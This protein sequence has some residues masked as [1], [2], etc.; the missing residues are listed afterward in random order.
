MSLFLSVFI[1]TILLTGVTIFLLIRKKKYGLKPFFISL[2]AFAISLIIV[3]PLGNKPLVGD[4]KKEASTFP[5]ERFM[6]DSVPEGSVVKVVGEAVSLNEQSI[7]YE[8]LFVLETEDGFFYVRNNN[9][10]HEEI[11][12]GELITVFGGYAG[13]GENNSPSISAQVIER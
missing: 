1:L 7:L 9:V 8:E 12:D 11:K 3:I 5:Y 2:I 6:N 10:E 13:K 4:Y